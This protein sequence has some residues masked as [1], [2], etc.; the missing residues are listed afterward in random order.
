MEVKSAESYDT[1]NDDSVFYRYVKTV[2]GDGDIV[3]I[4]SYDEMANALRETSAQFMQNFGS[5]LFTNIKFRD[6]FVMIGQKG[7]N[8]GKAIEIH[9][10]KKSKDFA[11]AAM[12]S[13]CVTFP[14]GIIHPVKQV[15]MQVN[16]VD[17]IVVKDVVPNCGLRDEC[18]RGEFAVHVYSGV[19]SDDEPK[20]C[21][22]GRYVIAKNVNDAG[23]GI[24]I[25]VVG[26]GKEIIKTAHFDT[27]AEDSTNLEIFLES[28]Y[29]NT[30]I[31]AVTF[32][33]ASAK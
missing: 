27:Y 11:P 2:V 32:D 1:F 22:D 30:I 31:I 33:E 8:K 4:A 5:Q 9:E 13:G 7:I 25:V 20:V 14:L 12:I 16:S 21:V 6:S 17:K 28:L 23:R 10:P 26:N 29:E 24:N 18:K 19:N 3:M 15:E